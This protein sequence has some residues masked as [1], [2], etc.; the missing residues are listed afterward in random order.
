MTAL[1]KTPG[2]G[3]TPPPPDPDDTTRPPL[4]TDPHDTTDPT[5]PA[6]GVD[7]AS[8][9]ASAGAEAAPRRRAAAPAWPYFRFGGV[10]SRCRGHAE[11]PWLTQ[12]RPSTTSP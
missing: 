9:V 8:V 3:E 1:Q 7:D 10:S 12:K 2:E 11:R 4:P 5:P 6:D